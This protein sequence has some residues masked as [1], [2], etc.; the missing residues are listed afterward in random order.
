MGQWIA[1]NLLLPVMYL[2]IDVAVLLGVVLLL[3][4]VID[5]F[6]NGGFK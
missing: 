2:L 6:L 1:N 4:M 3:I 5:H